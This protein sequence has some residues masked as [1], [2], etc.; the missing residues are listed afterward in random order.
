MYSAMKK[1]IAS[2]ANETMNATRFA[3]KNE[4]ERKK[5]KSTIG[6][7]LRTS[8]TAK[9]ANAAGATASSPMTAGEPQPHELPSTS[10]ST[11]VPRATLIVATP[12]TST[13]WVELS[14]RDSR[15]AASV[16][17][18][19]SAATGTLRKKID[20]QETLSTRKPPTTGPMAS[21][22]ALTPAQV[23]MARPR[24][25]GGKA[26]A[27][28]DSVAGIMNAGPTPWAARPAMSQASVV[29]RPM[30]ALDRP[31]T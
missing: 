2:I 14:S 29:D 22:S 20:C 6:S 8:A 31:N 16:T 15:A 7:A 21:A 11:S 28:I 9:A 25:C 1:N 13:W 30:K 19:A 26:L 5:R 17:N 3:P 12:G 23:P 4:R 10:A 27:M 24:S 18:T